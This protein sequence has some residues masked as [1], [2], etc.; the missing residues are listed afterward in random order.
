VAGDLDYALSA[1][2]ADTQGF[3]VARFGTRDIGTENS[4]VSGRFQYNPADTLRLKTV[5]RYS[6][7]E[8]DSVDQD[9]DSS[10][11]T[12]GLAI[13][14]DGHFRNRAFYGLVRGE[15]DSFDGHWT[16]ALAVQGVDASRDS[17][18]SSNPGGDNGRRVR[19]SYESTLR[20]GSD[21]FA[22]TL[23]AA[24]DHER[25]NFQ[26]LG[27]FLTPEQTIDR[28]I[29]TK[30]L[31]LQ[32]DARI[33][34]RIG[35]GAA[36][37]HD[38]NDR[39]DSDTTFRVQGSYRLGSGT[40][41]R[42]AAGSGIKNPGILE[43]FGFDPGTFIG[44]PDLKPEKSTGWEVGADQSF[45]DGRVLA[46]ITYFDNRLKHEISTIFIPPSFDSF[47]LN[48]GT[49]STQKGIELSAQARLDAWRIDASYTY[50]DAKQNGVEEVRRPPHIGSLNAGY[51]M[52]GDRLG[53]ALTVR[54]NGVT[55]DNDFGSFVQP[56]YARL[57]AFTLVN[58]GGDFAITHNVQLYGRVENLLGERYEEVYSYRSAG[59]GAYAG[60]RFTF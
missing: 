26:N 41:L 15:M 25:E 1:G 58:L 54:Y 18:S 17:F 24:F 50:V 30:G 27:P 40:R 29:T 39:F 49:E 7:T 28:Q 44:N 57:H 43:L 48:L 23:T 31:V 6:R 22:Q 21:A 60:A 19:A 8:G 56:A 13:D 20:F 35:F 34:D 42:A 45:A 14:G 10:S 38:D 46:G 55:N 53:V 36:V 5:L 3:P 11:P 2:Y 47:P 33:D 32:Y 37:R 51:R 59:R 52:L 16:N 4:V 9:F 12:Y